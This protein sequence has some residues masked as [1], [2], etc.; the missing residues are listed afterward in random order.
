MPT[1]QCRL[2][3]VE[4]RLENQHQMITESINERR[5]QSDK[6]Y[7]L[8]EEIQAD[9]SKMKGFTAGV[10]CVFGLIGWFLNTFYEKL[11]GH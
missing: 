9:I 7:K 6:T 11:S 8:L 4:E 10:A 2:A 3:K 1:V 5:R